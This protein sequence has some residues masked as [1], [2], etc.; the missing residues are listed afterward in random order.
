MRVRVN[1]FLSVHLDVVFGGHRSLFVLGIGGGAVL[2]V[3]VVYPPRD[4]GGEFLS[5]DRL[6]CGVIPTEVH[7]MGLEFVDEFPD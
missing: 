7:Q 2:K 5:E 6:N 1:A 3:S 4:M